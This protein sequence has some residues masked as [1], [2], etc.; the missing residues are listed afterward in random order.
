MEESDLIEPEYIPSDDVP[1]VSPDSDEPLPQIVPESVASS[2]RPHSKPDVAPVLDIW[3]EYANPSYRM[4]DEI[5]VKVTLNSGEYFFPVKIVKEY[6]KKYYL[7]GYRSKKTGLVYHHACSQTPT[8]NRRILKD[9]SNLSTRETQTYEYKTLSIQTYR[10]SG[11][12][13]ERID[14]SIDNRRDISK[15]AGKYMTAD[16]LHL[17]QKTKTVVIQRYWRGYMARCRADGIRQRNREYQSNLLQEE[18]IRIEKLKN[19]RD[20]DM[21]RRL[22]PSSNMDFEILYNE[23]DAW[24]KDEIA[25]IKVESQLIIALFFCLTNSSILGE[26]CTWRREKVG[27]FSP[28][29]R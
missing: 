2:S 23:L 22:H 15:T 3:P 18:T 6:A 16:E 26:Y 4:P 21:K 17:I 29:G 10:E 24:R 20:E 7:G 13:M 28:F 14:L 12:Q 11:T 27:P 19:E 5:E 8:E 1:E 25:K 9:N